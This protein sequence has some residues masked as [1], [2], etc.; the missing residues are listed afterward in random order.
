MVDN[1]F[2]PYFIQLLGGSA[3]YYD[4]TCIGGTDYGEMF[5]LNIDLL[6]TYKIRT[7]FWNTENYCN[8]LFVDEPFWCECSNGSTIRIGKYKDI[9][10]ND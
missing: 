9:W 2:S 8:K 3:Q 7:I 10:K 4:T 5:W 1:N 6:N